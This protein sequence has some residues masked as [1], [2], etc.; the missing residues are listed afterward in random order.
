MSHYVALVIGD[1]PESQLAPYDENIEVAPYYTGTVSEDEKQ[2]MLDYYNNERGYK[3]SS[4]EECYEYKGRDWNG[5]RYKFV[6]GEWKE[7]STYN[8]NSKWD[9][10]QL[11]GRWSGGFI[12]LKEG[13]EGEVGNGSL[14][15]GNTAGVD[16]AYKRDI[17]FDKIDRKNFI[18]YAVLYQGL[19][20]SR[21]EMGWFG[22]SMNEQ[23]DEREWENKVWELIDSTSDDTLFSFY[24]LHI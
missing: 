14:V 1:D 21:G 24:D 2:R 5:N 3:F 4:F 20:I 22:V 15:M 23:Y 13:A 7:F 12:K 11:G 17:D 8:P 18:P 19:W 9:W 10:Y 6:D 16:Q